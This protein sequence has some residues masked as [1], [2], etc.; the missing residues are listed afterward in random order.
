MSDKKKIAEKEGN[1]SK[2]GKNQLIEQLCSPTESDD[3]DF[4]EAN[5][6]FGPLPS[7]LKIIDV[8]RILR[9]HDRLT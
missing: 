2:V 4:L 1:N 8:D 7:A 6:Y 9:E 5:Q 3:L